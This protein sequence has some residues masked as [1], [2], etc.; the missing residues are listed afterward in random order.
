MSIYHYTYFQ[1]YF[2]IICCEICKISLNSC[3][4][5]NDKNRVCPSTVMA[6]NTEYFCLYSISQFNTL[7]RHADFENNFMILKVSHPG[8]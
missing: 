5:V 6:Q 7:R 8:I 1:R 3:T 4:K 2:L